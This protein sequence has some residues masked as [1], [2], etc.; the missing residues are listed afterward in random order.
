MKA[1]I[2]A[3]SYTQQAKL[4]GSDATRYGDFG[5][6]VAISGDTVI[7]GSS[8]ELIDNSVLGSAYIF[9]RSEAGWSQQQ[10]LTVN[11]LN[12]GAF[13]GGSVAIFN[14][15]AI[16]GAHGATVGTTI[17]QGA[18]YVYVRSGTTWTQVQKLTASD[19]GYED[20]FG[21]AV[22]FSGDTA[23]IGAHNAETDVSTDHT[24][25]VYVFVR[26][27]MT[28]VEQQ[29]LTANDGQDL[30]GFGRYLAIDGDT[31]VISSHGD[32]DRGGDSGSAYVFNR[33]GTVW[34]QQQKLLAADGA[35][36][37]NFGASVD[38]S[39]DTVIVGAPYHDIGSNGNQGSVYVY[40][41]TGTVWAQQQQL[42]AADGL[43]DDTFGVGVTISGS[44]LAI[45]APGDAWK[46]SAYIFER[47]GTTWT[48]QQ[49]L[50][51]SDG[52]L[53]DSFGASLGIS[54]DMIIAGAPNAS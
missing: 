4:I 37:D 18:A 39:G 51:A 42:T 40:L 19:G 38:I 27:G 30:D 33:S 2:T 21:V 5:R 13:F 44:T 3:A 16:V 31:A 54:G 28:W 52:S 17:H 32:D 11:D 23:I 20:Y 47:S 29:T 45:G 9:V 50:T 49:I 15:T 43:A 53:Y 46:G 24:G 7:V 25:K 36:S 12:S 22:A 6:D 26:N 8:Q 1:A 48:E 10:R 14:D 41:R 35:T 34:I